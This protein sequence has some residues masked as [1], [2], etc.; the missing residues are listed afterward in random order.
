MERLG[1]M[2]I[3]KTI[4]AA[5][6]ALLFSSQIN[7][8]AVY[9][10]NFRTDFLNNS[11]VIYAINL[12]T[13]NANDI[14][15]NGIIDF[16]EGETSGTFLNAIDR[17]DELKREGVTALHVLPITPVG[18]IK[19]LGTAGSLYAAASFNS[20]NP[21]LKDPNSDL[22]IEEQ[23]RQF[24][25]AA[26]ERGISVIIDLPACGSYDLFLQRPEL[27]LKDSS[28]Q[29]I[30]PTDWTDVRLLDAGNE[31]KINN[32]VL[33]L[34][35][36]FV[37]LMINIGADGIRADVAHCK[38]A[39]FW[40]ELIDYSRKKYPQ[41]LWLAE[42]SDSWKEPVVP[43]T[44][45]TPYDKLLKA[46]FD[47]YYGSY[48][49]LKNWK[50]GS[51]LKKQ[52]EHNFALEKII[53]EKKGVIGSFTTHDEL[54]PILEKGVNYSRMITWLNVTLPLN[55]Y[56]IDGFDTGDTYVYFWANRKAPVTYTDDEEYFAHRGKIDIFNFS[57]KPGGSVGKLKEDF[58]RAN[59]IKKI[60]NNIRTNGCFK[61]IPTSSKSAFAYTISDNQMTVI[62]I[63]S[64]NF[65]G[66]ITTKTNIPKL[67]KGIH[68][69]PINIINAPTIEKGKI[70]SKLDS[71][72]VQVFMF[73]NPQ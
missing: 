51:D 16:E 30:I 10:N 41:F 53:G 1:I 13:F 3:K 17:L 47:G 9:A 38:P 31:T 20:L 6:M 21:Q 19:A 57:R 64:L 35:K 58:P 44:V 36:E 39:K 72:E 65:N 2:G 25:Q 12:R 28:G 49:D 73:E 7:S 15:R 46:G 71:G 5:A 67:T 14:N 69:H 24:I 26:H 54:S 11:T 70:T 42:S 59:E 63:G 43:N 18:K 50:T 23:A 37:D 48:F 62:V 45:F 32:D 29:P 66:T 22:P 27:F 34:Y 55:A 68:V 4:I 61:F 40:K 33:N 56:Y 60:V 8:N 52:V